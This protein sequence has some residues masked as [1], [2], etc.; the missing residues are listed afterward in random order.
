MTLFGI[1]LDPLHL[2]IFACYLLVPKPLQHKIVH[3]VADLAGDHCH[4][5]LRVDP[6]LADPLGP[7]QDRNQG[8][9]GQL[10]LFLEVGDY[11]G[12][13]G[14]TVHVCLK[15][16]VGRDAGWREV[17]VYSSP[18]PRRKR[19]RRSSPAALASSRPVQWVLS[20]GG[21]PKAKSTTR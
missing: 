3:S 21:G 7:F 4:E 5:L 6:E 10:G 20:P 8:V 17:H 12:K 1:L 18:T 14:R 2:P 13:N 9:A 19:P 15:D 11:V 16:A